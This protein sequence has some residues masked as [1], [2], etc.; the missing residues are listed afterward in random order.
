M[1]ARIASLPSRICLCIGVAVLAAVACSAASC[2]R[3][4]RVSER[5]GLFRKGPN[6]YEKFLVATW[7]IGFGSPDRPGRFDSTMSQLGFQR[8]RESWVFQDRVGKVTVSAWGLDS[9]A[10]MTFEPAQAPSLPAPILSILE[11]RASRVRT[12]IE[13]GTLLFRM[14]A[15]TLAWSVDGQSRVY[16]DNVVVRM[17]G[18][19]WVQ[20]RRAIKQ[21]AVKP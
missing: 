8:D 19:K 10:Y 1:N 2:D 6:S 5:V 3:V 16:S 4:R 9:S 13:L 12:G 18:G 17:D 14:E 11:H 21:T 7:R 20:T 15:D